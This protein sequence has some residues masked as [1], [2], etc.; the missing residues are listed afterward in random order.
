MTHSVRR[1]RGRLVGRARSSP[2][3][4][5]PARRARRRRRAPAPRV[6]ARAGS[7]AARPR[8]RRRPRPARPRRRRSRRR[9]AGSSSSSKRTAGRPPSGT[10]SRWPSAAS[11]T[12]SSS[13]GSCPASSS[14][15]ATASTGEWPASTRRG[16]AMADRATSSRTTRSPRRTSGAPWRWRTAG[17]N[18]NGSQFFIVLADDTGLQPQYSI[19]GHVTSGMDVVDA[20]AAMPNSGGQSN[21]AIDPVPMIVHRDHDPLASHSRGAPMTRATIATEIGDIEVELYDQ[22]APR[23]ARTSST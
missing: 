12:A 21:A 10:S 5:S 17:P 4:S 18:T 8:R 1:H 9:G 20:I 2:R 15:A 19:L 22:S 6:A 11:T 23:A 14:R 16:S 13:I 7:P 3:S